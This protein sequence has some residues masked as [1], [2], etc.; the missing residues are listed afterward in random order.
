MQL[1]QENAESNSVHLEVLGKIKLLRLRE[2]LSKRFEVLLVLTVSFMCMGGLQVP[3]ECLGGPQVSRSAWK[4]V[5]A[6]GII[7]IF[8]TGFSNRPPT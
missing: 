2:I 1:H 7:N 8:F 4:C 6:H 5:E 3:S